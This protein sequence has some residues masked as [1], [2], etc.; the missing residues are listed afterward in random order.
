[1]E[2]GY[3]RVQGQDIPLIKG[4]Y[5]QRQNQIGT[6]V[7]EIPLN[8]LNHR[9]LQGET[10]DLYWRDQLV[11]SGLVTDQPAIKIG[12]GHDRL[13]LTLSCEDQLTYLACVDAK[14]TVE[15][16]YQN[17]RVIDIL[18]NL[19][20]WITFTGQTPAWS[21][22]F[23]VSTM[24]DTDIRTTLDL[25]T[26]STIWSQII[27]TVK[28]VP[29]VFIRFDSVDPVTNIYS[30]AIGAFGDLTHRGYQH[31]N[32]LDIR[33]DRGNARNIRDIVALSGRSADSA[34]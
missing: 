31:D 24:I 20:G 15:A 26:K 17:I 21:L 32:L 23:D 10:I 33:L 9:T 30:F 14:F 6:F 29:R 34:Y 4:S 27:E 12:S 25:R 2:H 5:D 3:A 28:S 18:Q 19:L 8:D 16:H 1:M 22:A 13:I 11:V 7:I